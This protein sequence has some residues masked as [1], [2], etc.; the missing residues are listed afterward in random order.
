MSNEI[1]SQEF[2]DLARLEA[3]IQAG[4]I[5]FVAV[6]LALTEIREK[7][8]YRK[9]YDTFDEYCEIR[10]GWTRQRA[11]QLIGAAAVVQE[12][13]LL[14]VNKKLSTIVD[15]AKKLPAIIDSESL[16]REI[17]KIPPQRRSEV[18]EKAAASGRPL[19]ARTIAEIAKPILEAEITGGLEKTKSSLTGASGKFD[20][21][22]HPIPAKII[23]VWIRAESEAASAAQLVSK[24]RSVFNDA[25]D[26]GDVI[27][28][29]IFYLGGYQANM[30][31]LDTLFSNIKLIAP[32]GVCT[33]CQG[34]LPETCTFC[35]GCGFLS[36]FAYKMY[37]LDTVKAMRKKA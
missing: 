23:G 11:S 16:A 5:T 14:P 9:D 27:Y 19:T 2:A 32:H 24:L 17:G 18:V 10:W 25:R 36:A 30:A 33:A 26:E 35:R 21:E 8:L 1:T 3:T 15:S 31:L 37:A 4:K 12:L 34:V 20:K 29:E 7:R 6:G 13:N 28:R 22:G